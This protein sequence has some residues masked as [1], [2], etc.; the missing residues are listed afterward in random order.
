MTNTI[1]ASGAD[2]SPLGLVEVEID[3]GVRRG[4]QATQIVSC[5]PGSGA[6]DAFVCDWNAGA[7]TD[8]HSYTMRARAADVHGNLSAWSAPITVIGDATPP[9]LDISAAAQ[10][11]LSDGQLNN[12]EMRLDGTLVDER[13]AV[14]VQACLTQMILG[15]EVDVCQTAVV[16]D[17]DSWS[18]SLPGSYDGVTAVLSI[19]GFDGAGNP[20]NAISQTVWLDT[21][22]PVIGAFVTPDLVQMAGN[23]LALF[24]SGTVTDSSGLTAV[25]AIII[26]PD[27]SSVA[28]TGAA[29]GDAWEVSYRF[30]QNGDYR[31]VVLLTDGVGN[32]RFSEVWPFTVGQTVF[33]VYLPI[34]LK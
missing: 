14:S 6:A 8:G 19:V 24:A 1:I 17:D 3:D 33:Q 18:L 12:A 23:D 26:Q 29:N 27:N 21:V 20:S 4:P 32:R 10:A 34:V 22:T 7:V 2:E 25:R 5:V 11:A 28:V 13:T 15:E 30:T 16:L 9:V 31:A